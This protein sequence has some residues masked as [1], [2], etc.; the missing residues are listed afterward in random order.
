MSF[1]TVPPMA[2]EATP[3]SSPTSSY[4]NSR[5]AAVALMVMEVVTWSSG[6]P[7][8]SNRMSSMESMATPVFP[9][10]PWARGWSLS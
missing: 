9:T 4:S 3:C 5:I 7:S 1:W 2:V 8:S 6:I 10:S